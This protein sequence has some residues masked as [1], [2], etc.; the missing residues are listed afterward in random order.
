[1]G[2]GAAGAAA[3]AD[4]FAFRDEN[5]T[6]HYSNVPDN[7]RYKL[8]VRAPLADAGR[9]VDAQRAAT[10][11]ARAGDYDAMIER[12]AREATIHPALVRAVIVVESGFNPR[13]ISLKGALGLMQLLPE[14]AR[15]YGA[16]NALDPAQNILAGTR[17]LADLLARFDSNLELALAAYNAGEAAVRRYGGRVPPYRET[18]AYIPSVLQVYRAL[19]AAGRRS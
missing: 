9:K 10:W 12:A 2:L 7:P 16:F 4:I 11:L 18:R 17:Y 8:M 3:R 19:S 5:G 6:I 1:M 15:R 14:T 13:A